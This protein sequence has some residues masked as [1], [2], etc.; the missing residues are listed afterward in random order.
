V[1]GLIDSFLGYL[2]TRF[3]NIGVFVMTRRSVGLYFVK[4]MLFTVTL[5][6]IGCAGSRINSA[7]FSKITNGMTKADVESILGPGK[8]QSSSS[9][10]VPG[11]SGAGISVPGQSMSGENLVWQEGAK[12]I[13]VMIL[14]GKVIAKAAN[15]L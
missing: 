6:A 10:S 8:V 11:F 4:L 3:N 5:I 7:N 15:G 12:V 14:N 13:T 9:A 2:S 1:T